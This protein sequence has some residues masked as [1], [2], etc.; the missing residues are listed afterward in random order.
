MT[1]ERLL[2]DNNYVKSIE[3]SN[4]CVYK[5]K[6]TSQKIYINT[7]TN[8]IHGTE[9]KYKFLILGKIQEGLQ[10]DLFYSVPGQHKPYMSD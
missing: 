4:L 3:F 7:K 10:L 9:T 2:K 8:R 1:L 6:N 5:N